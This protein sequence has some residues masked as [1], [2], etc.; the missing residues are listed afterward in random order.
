MSKDEARFNLLSLFLNFNAQTKFSLIFTLK[1]QQYD[2]R[3][4]RPKL[5][6]SPFLSS[7][8]TIEKETTKEQLFDKSYGHGISL[9]QPGNAPVQNSRRNNLSAVHGD[10]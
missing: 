10:L 5:V 3:I 8:R 9:A 1:I 6:H 2:E 7:L 4:I